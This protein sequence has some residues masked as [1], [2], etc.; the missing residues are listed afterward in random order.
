MTFRQ[1]VSYLTASLPDDL[2]REGSSPLLLI[3]EE[4]V[5][6]NTGSRRGPSRPTAGVLAASEHTRGAVLR[7]WLDG[8]GRGSGAL[9]GARSGVLDGRFED[10]RRRPPLRLPNADPCVLGPGLAVSVLA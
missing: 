10:V 2:M 6:Q 5:S 3:P 8:D 1:P 9:F 4:R 7:C